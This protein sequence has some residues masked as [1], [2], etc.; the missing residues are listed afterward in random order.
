MP[1]QPPCATHLPTAL[2]SAAPSAERTR[3]CAGPAPPTAR[4][5]RWRECM[6]V[7]S[8]CPQAPA[9]DRSLAWA[10]GWQWARWVGGRGCQP[11]A[12]G[13]NVPSRQPLHQPPPSAARVHP[14]EAMETSTTFCSAATPPARSQSLTMMWCSSRSSRPA[15]V[16]CGAQWLDGWVP[17]GALASPPQASM[18]G[19]AAPAPTCGVNAQVKVHERRVEGGALH[20]RAPGGR[21][22][23]GR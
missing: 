7:G 4:T 14:P 2:R 15:R 22:S 18:P 20:R 5:A 17:L 1:V 3:G 6:R 23:V 21:H 9:T 11:G 16:G 12:A 19:A 13:S 10:E 8:A